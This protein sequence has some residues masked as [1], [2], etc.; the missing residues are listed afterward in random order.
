MSLGSSCLDLLRERKASHNNRCPGH[1]PSPFPR[2]PTSM[3][4]QT[5]LWLPSLA[6]L[7]TAWGLCRYCQEAGLLRIKWARVLGKQMWDCVLTGCL[8]HT[9]PF[10]AS[11][12]FIC[13]VMTMSLLWTRIKIEALYQES[14]HS[15]LDYFYFHNLYFT[16]ECFPCM[17]TCTTCESSTLSIRRRCH[18]FPDTG[19]ANDCESPYIT[20]GN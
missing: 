18:R 14:T 11:S 20:A 16:Q 6:P 2:I 7:H 9:C 5:D 4:A 12:L 8:G 3:R 1:H 19:A 17:H 13:E 10:L 15:P